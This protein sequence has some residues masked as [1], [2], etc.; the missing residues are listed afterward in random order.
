MLTTA[1]F[2]LNQ[3]FNVSQLSSAQ[4][5]LKDL[6]QQFSK[7]FSLYFREVILTLTPE[8]DNVDATKTSGGIFESAATSRRYF[9]NI[10][11]STIFIS[12]CANLIPIQ[13]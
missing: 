7:A 10:L 9:F 2:V 11:A 3:F 5:V 12:I 1:S 13:L 4:E 8:H 6:R